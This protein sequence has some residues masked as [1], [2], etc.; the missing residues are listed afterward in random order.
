MLC[1]GVLCLG[2]FCPD[3]DFVLEWT[4]GVLG[5]FNLIRVVYTFSR[6]FCRKTFCRS[7][8]M[9]QDILSR[10]HFVVRHFVADIL[11]EDI[12]SQDILSYTR[13]AYAPS[14]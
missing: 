7:D 5:V 11:S 12:L 10:G 9:S 1:P 6:T 2:G 3:G 14:C 8:I 13:N 4:C